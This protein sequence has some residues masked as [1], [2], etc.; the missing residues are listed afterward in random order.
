MIPPLIC[1]PIQII[2]EPTQRKKRTLSE[3]LKQEFSQQTE[4]ELLIHLYIAA[5]SDHKNHLL[6]EVS[7]SVR[8]WLKDIVELRLIR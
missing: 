6:G 1:I 3:K 5:E 4:K 2:G 8:N 7:F